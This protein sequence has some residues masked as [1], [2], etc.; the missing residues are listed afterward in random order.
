MMMMII[1]IMMVKDALEGRGSHCKI[2]KQ[3]RC[4]PSSCFASRAQLLHGLAGAQAIENMTIALEKEQQNEAHNLE[5]RNHACHV[6]LQQ[7]KHRKYCAD[8]LDDNEVDA[9]DLLPYP[10]ICVSH[11]SMEPFCLAVSLTALIC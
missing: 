8:Q 7:V 11:V 4:D 6:R 3:Q 5:G 10:C 1:I 9:K 2:G